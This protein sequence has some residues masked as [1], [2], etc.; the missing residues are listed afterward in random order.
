G[1]LGSSGAQSASAAAGLVGPNALGELGAL[2]DAQ[3][4]AL[5]A[6]DTAAGGV[7]TGG[8]LFSGISN[9]FSSTGAIGS[10]FSEGGALSGIGSAFSAISPVI[11]FIGPVLGIGSLIGGLVGNKKPSNF[12]SG[13]LLDL[14]SGKV[15][16]FQSS[17]NQ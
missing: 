10:L 1:G 14:A 7:S 6:A 12:S 2:S 16:G 17:G 15:S 3:I 11:P 8:G 5:A 9:I 13:D 4:S